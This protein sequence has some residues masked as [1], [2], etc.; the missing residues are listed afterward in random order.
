[1]PNPKISSTTIVEKHQCS[2]IAY[3]LWCSFDSSLIKYRTFFGP[4]CVRDYLIAIITD[5]KYI[6]DTY[7]K[8]PRKM[9][10]LTAEDISKILKTDKCGFCYKPLMRKLK[11]KSNQYEPIVRDHC[12]ITGEF[13]W[14]AHQSCNLQ[15]ENC[16]YIPVLFHNLSSYDGSII[17]KEITKIN[18]VTDIKIIPSNM[19]KYIAFKTIIRVDKQSKK[20]KFALYF[21]DSLRHLPTS[22]STLVDGLSNENFTMTQKMFPEIPLEIIRRKGLFCYSYIDSYEKY[23]ETELPPIEKFYSS[24]SGELPSI[25][26]YNYALDIF[27]RLK[28]KN[29]DD[30]NQFYIK[31]D[32]HST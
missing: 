3:L 10:K 5:T 20:K 6:Y 22:L 31:L 16:N 9:N 27:K 30:Y 26:D 2:T 11:N 7:Y 28:M 13:R 17:I 29:I 14:L 23:N 15:V 4:N 12:H 19:Q 32:I 1:M 8:L 21:M 18:V 24:L 25:E